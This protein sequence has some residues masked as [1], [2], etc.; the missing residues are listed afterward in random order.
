MYA[1]SWFAE[2]HLPYYPYT[3]ISDAQL[4]HYG[5]GNT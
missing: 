2:N 3:P 4:S 5:K 1:L